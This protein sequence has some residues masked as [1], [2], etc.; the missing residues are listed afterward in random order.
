MRQA[1]PPSAR[2]YFAPL[3]TPTSLKSTESGTPVHSL[4]LTMPSTCCGVISGFG[5]R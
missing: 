1:S 2:K 5:V 4:L 3:C